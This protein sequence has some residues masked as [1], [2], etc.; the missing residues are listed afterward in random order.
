MAILGE[1]RRLI[2]HRACVC[3]LS[4]GFCHIMRDSQSYGQSYVISRVK[5]IIT[6][7]IPVLQQLD[8][9]KRRVTRG[10]TLCS[11]FLPT[12]TSVF[13]VFHL[14]KMIWQLYCRTDPST[15]EER[16]SDFNVAAFSGQHDAT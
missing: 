13:G 9:M 3:V 1:F 11:L 5:R 12:F 6:T 4:D 8:C 16:T 10:N 2:T 7:S 15:K 14:I